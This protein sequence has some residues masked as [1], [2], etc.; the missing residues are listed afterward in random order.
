TLVLPKAG[1]DSLRELTLAYLNNSDRFDA[2]VGELLG[3]EES[4]AALVRLNWPVAMDVPYLFFVRSSF[5]MLLLGD[6]QSAMGTGLD[7]NWGGNQ[8]LFPP[9]T[10]EP[11]KEPFVYYSGLAHTPAMLNTL[12]HDIYFFYIIHADPTFINK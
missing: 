8:K 4:N 1:R 2:N 6:N 5:S 9:N 11:S 3:D 12:I 10:I 7:K